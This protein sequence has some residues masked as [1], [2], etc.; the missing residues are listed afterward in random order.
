MGYVVTHAR[1]NRAVV[2][3]KNRLI[4]TP[5]PMNNK[6]RD[7]SELYSPKIWEG[8][9]CFLLAGGDS[10]KNFNYSCLAG[11]LTVGVN[12]TFET[13][14]PT[15]NYSMDVSFWNWLHGY[16]A[17]EEEGRIRL[18]KWREYSGIKLFLENPG[19]DF[20][21]GTFF[22]KRLSE[23]A[24]SLSIKR[25]IYGGTNSGFGALSFIIA[26]GCKLIYLLGLDLKVNGTSTHWHDGYPGQTVE[27]T[28]RVL[29][30]FQKVFTEFAPSIQR[31][32]VTV[33]NLNPGSA[34]DCFSKADP[35]SILSCAH[36]VVPSSSGYAEMSKVTGL[37]PSSFP[38][39]TSF[40]TKNSGYELEAKKLARS[41]KDMNLDYEI[42]GIVDRKNW[43]LNIRYKPVLIKK[44]LER[45]YPRPVLYVD[46]DAIFLK[47]P[48]LLRTLDADVA[49]HT[50]KWSVYGRDRADEM[51]G[52]TV[53]FKN[54]PTAKGI[55]DKW[56]QL[57]E[58]TPLSVWDQKILQGILGNNYYNLPPEYCT[59]FDSMGSVVK[60]PV[61]LH[62]QASRRLKQSGRHLHTITRPS[63]RRKN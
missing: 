50:V 11:E 62:T 34:L 25:G 3:R 44:M 59:I 52:G 6:S 14:E 33:V 22:I 37:Y 53:Y 19:K 51:L 1:R 35:S 29:T 41:L 12:R 56:V 26:M 60:E 15:V 43:Q 63:R 20:G 40:Y 8:K 27:R 39:I 57:C 32:G 61:I 10:L 16:K 46:A 18:Q 42:V 36:T 21:V 13:F 45:Y 30:N 4:T 48:E 31:L 28:S 47:F 24:L 55:L 54:T 49:I 5:S 2:H 23:R 9:R 7:I 38:I 17:S 58:T